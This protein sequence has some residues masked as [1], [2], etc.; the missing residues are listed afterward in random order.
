MLRKILFQ[1][2]G[3]LAGV[4]AGAIAGQMFK[5]TWKVMSGQD[6]KPQATDRA[7]GWVETTL[8]AALEGAVYGGVKALVSRGSAAGFEKA[9]GTWPD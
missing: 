1:P 6:Q 7:R 3:A 5:W 2:W 4:A 9:T 8:A